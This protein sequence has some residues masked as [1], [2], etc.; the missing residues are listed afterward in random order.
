MDCPLAAS[1][2]LSPLVEHRGMNMAKVKKRK[3]EEGREGEGEKE[4]GGGCT[5]GRMGSL[6][7]ETFSLYID[8]PLVLKIRGRKDDGLHL[9]G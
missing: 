1:L 6:F 2:S 9:R 7:Q 8:L 5:V 3:D 4:R